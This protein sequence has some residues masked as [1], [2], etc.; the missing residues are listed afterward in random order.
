M[1]RLNASIIEDLLSRVQKPGRYMGCERNIIIKHNPRLRMA[2]S[3]PDLYEVG[4]SNNG[5]RILYD[6]INSVPEAA[7]ER[8]FAVAEDFERE[9]RDNDVPLYTLETYTPIRELDLLGF[10]VSHELLC[11][12]VLQ[13]LDLGGIPLRRKERKN[14]MPIVIAGGEAVSNP[15]PLS[16]FID[17]FYIGDG[18]EGILDIVRA[19]L[20]AKK[21]GLDRDGTI[22][23]IGAV[24]GVL[25]P[26]RYSM[27]YDG[28]KIT[29]LNGPTVR[30]RVYRGSD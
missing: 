9:L 30:K 6:I 1:A 21:A 27:T 22:E 14:G 7:C 29:G 17:A 12:N 19:V 4:M 8:V 2:L 13:I 25:I 10:N 18:E 16:D 5:L 11:T 20:S 24:G 28:C 23:S 3:Y 15:F 26:S